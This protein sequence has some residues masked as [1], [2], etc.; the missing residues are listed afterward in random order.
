MSKKLYV[1]GIGGTI[2]SRVIK[3]LTMLLATGVKLDNGL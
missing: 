3:A 1:F 2:G